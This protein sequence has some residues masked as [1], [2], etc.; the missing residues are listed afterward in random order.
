[1][2]KIKVRFNLGRGK[3]YMKWK[4]QSKSGVEY[5]S[6]EDVQLVIHNCVLKN[7]RKTAQK[8]F[9]GEN[10]D[11]CAWILCESI[12]INHKENFSQVACNLIKYSDTVYKLRYNPKVLPYWVTGEDNLDNSEFKTIASSNKELFI[13]N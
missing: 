13:I 9:E 6:P 7:N 5:H 11:V 12:E 3:N 8:I 10:K 1:M 2:R 4:I